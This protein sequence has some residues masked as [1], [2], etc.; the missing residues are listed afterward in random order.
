MTFPVF[1]DVITAY[2]NQKKP[3]YET[4]VFI[5][6]SGR[7]SRIGFRVFPRYT[8]K[9]PLVQMIEDRDEQMLTLMLGF[10]L[11]MRGQLNAFLYRDPND[12]TVTNEPIGTGDGTTKAFQLVRDYGGFPEPVENLNGVP[13]LTIDEVLQADTDYTVSAAGLVTFDTAPVADSVISWTGSY[14]YRC[15]FTEDSKDF[16]QML[17]GWHEA[18]D[19]EFVGSI[20]SIV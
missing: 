13:L 11:Q 4:S 10:F 18:S 12:N 15:R 5:A 8:F 6:K 16:V 20:R 17:S 9:L 2:E 3:E 7:E 1:P 19:V 14:Y